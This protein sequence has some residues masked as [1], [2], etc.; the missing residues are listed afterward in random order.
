[1]VTRTRIPRGSAARRTEC[2][3]TTIAAAAAHSPNLRRVPV[4]GRAEPVMAIEL[5]SLARVASSRA[6]AAAAAL[7]L[8]CCTCCI[9]SS[10]WL[11]AS[12]SCKGVQGMGAGEVCRRS[13]HGPNCFRGASSC[14]RPVLRT[15]HRGA[16]T[17]ARQCRCIVACQR[18]ATP[19]VLPQRFA[20]PGCLLPLLRAGT[21]HQHLRCTRPIPSAPHH[22]AHQA[23]RT[24]WRCSRREVWVSLMEKNMGPSS[25]SH[26]GSTAVTHCQ[27]GQAAGRGVRG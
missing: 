11:R 8:S 22:Q 26:S 23:Q 2:S 7:A 12:R 24:F 5:R 25:A 6:A 14:A 9:S 10:I 17:G 27:G 16:P 3:H 4:P 13:N 21:W 1:M 20:A 15:Q 18:S 19:T